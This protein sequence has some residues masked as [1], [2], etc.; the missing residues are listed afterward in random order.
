MNK[1]LTQRATTAS[2]ALSIAPL[3]LT[4]ITTIMGLILSS[5]IVSATNDSVVDE[6][7]ITVPVSCTMTGT[8]MDSHNA[9]IQNGLYKDNIGTTT[10]HAF[11][12]DNEGF[13]IYAAGYTGNEIGGT[14]SNELVGTNASSN[15]TIESGI[16]TTAG[17]PES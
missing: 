1:H 2:S 14:N 5:S 10:L 12:N 16:A 8:G 7:S 11:C 15:A 9:E 3:A 6:V 17:S 13:A 4:G